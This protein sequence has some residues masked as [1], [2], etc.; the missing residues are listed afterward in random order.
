M[1]QKDE[2]VL[3][4]VYMKTKLIFFSFNL[5]G[6]FWAFKESKDIPVSLKDQH[7]M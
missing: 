5:D 6:S 1:T 2:D 4:A 7:S 3:I